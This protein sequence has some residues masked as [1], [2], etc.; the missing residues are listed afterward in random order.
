MTSDLHLLCSSSAVHSDP[1][2]CLDVLESKASFG[3]WLKDFTESEEEKKGEA[4]KDIANPPSGHVIDL[5]KRVVELFERVDEQMKRSKCTERMG[6]QGGDVARKCGE[7]ELLCTRLRKAEEEGREK[8][9]KLE[10][11]EERVGKLTR[12]LQTTPLVPY[13]I[14]EQK[15]FGKTVLPHECKC[16]YCGEN[17]QPR[18]NSSSSDSPEVA[19]HSTHEARRPRC[20][21]PG[22]R[23]LALCR[24]RSQRAP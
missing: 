19:L 23:P 14:F 13:A 21:A 24:P 7:A 2:P 1:S 6:D 12:R 4:M 10:E 17:V 16:V 22:R 20:P 9:Q 5:T 11:L 8:D 15:H 3:S 18:V